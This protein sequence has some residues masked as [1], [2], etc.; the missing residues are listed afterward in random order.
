MK[1]KN[2][3]IFYAC[4]IFF[5]VLMGLLLW[6]KYQQQQQ[7]NLHRQTYQKWKNKKKN[8]QNEYLF[9]FRNSEKAVIQEKEQY[10]PDQVIEQKQ[11]LLPYSRWNIA[12]Y[13]NIFWPK[14]KKYY[15]IK[16]KILQKTVQKKNIIPFVVKEINKERRQRVKFNLIFL[17]KLNISVQNLKTKQ[18]LITQLLHFI[19]NPQISWKQINNFLQENF[20]NQQ[21][22]IIAIKLKNS[23]WNFEWTDS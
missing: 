1:Q 3:I 15:H 5:I 22:K 23:T 14:W 21:S 12:N 4:L 18:S 16:S 8:S 13:L 7:T 9:T 6:Q 10:F 2:K 11:N 20:T 17:K 19:Q